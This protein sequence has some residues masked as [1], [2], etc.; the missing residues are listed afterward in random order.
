MFR[1]R[2]T[3]L[4]PATFCLGSDLSSPTSTH[5]EDQPAL[6]GTS[7]GEDHAHNQRNQHNEHED[8]QLDGGEI[9]GG[10]A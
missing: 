2:V 6:T 10:E 8:H 9:G 1:E 4:E 7:S 3:G 5:N